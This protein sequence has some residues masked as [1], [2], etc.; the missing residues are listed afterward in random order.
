[1]NDIKFE[2]DIKSEHAV[3]LAPV[4]FMGFDES[5]IE[6][7]IIERFERIALRFAERV[8]VES[9]EQSLTY[10]AL[11]HSANQ[12][13]Q[14]I[15]TRLGESMEPV[16]L[17]FDHNASL[18]VALLAVLKAGKA[19]VV[20]DQTH[21]PAR[22]A[23]QVEEIQIRLLV[24]DQSYV[25]KAEQILPTPG[26]IVTMET[27]GECAEAAHNP[28]IHLPG[29]QPAALYLTSGSTG[30]PKAVA[31][32][33]S[34][35]LH[36]IWYE[37]KEDQLNAQDHIGLIFACSYAASSH[38]LFS[39]LLSG[40]CL[41]LYDIRRQGIVGLADW[42]RQ[43]EI[44]RLHIAAPLFRQFLNS[45]QPSDFFP[46]M[47]YMTPASQQIYKSDLTRYWQHF[48]AT[49]LL[50]S[51]FA[52]SE[53]GIICRLLVT[54]ETEISGNVVPVGYPLPGKEVFILDESGNQLGADQIGE[55]AVRSRYL[56]AGYWGKPQLTEEKFRSNGDASE[57]TIYRMGDWG[58][59]RADGCLEFL[60]RK[61]E[62]VKIRGFRVEL[63]EIEAALYTLPMVK[64]AAVI[65][66]KRPETAEKPSE[67]M[68]IAYLVANTQPEPTPA[69]L[70]AALA[71]ILPEAMI[72]ARF[73]LLE[74]LPMTP[75]G[76]IDRKSLPLLSDQL[77]W[78]RP[79]SDTP[80]LPPRTPIEVTL[81]S[82]WQE[83]LGVQP[84][85]VDDRFLELGGDSL[86][87]MQVHARIFSQLQTNVPAR[88]LFECATIADLAVA[89]TAYHA[90]QL[91]E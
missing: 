67:A 26:G 86:R 41:C 31:R 62:M 88:L 6:R 85:G 57:P 49:S 5:E 28:G 81:V 59:L 63:G 76:K 12:V 18:I 69:T 61:D 72:P 46:A 45:L 42:L 17:L 13:A 2:N 52:S 83:V 25:V 53:T 48:P 4:D 60:G 3:A 24:T 39:A 14:A 77:Q 54:P 65:A 71:N 58:R 7:S 91:V 8:A 35:I 55:I 20:L 75:N 27:V 90:A 23:A 66:H 51:R 9:S 38:D 56:A 37:T 15:L 64:A 1:M 29:D 70:R 44:T 73:V 32:K 87:S 22:L 89:I 74:A 19:Y 10:A 36:R 11:N 34:T 80:Y 82:I 43:S 79:P 78:Q 21:P 50:V 68:L 47:R 40:A 16:A 30:A 33:Q 84:I